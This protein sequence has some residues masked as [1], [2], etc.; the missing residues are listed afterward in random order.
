MSIKML[1]TLIA[2]AEHDTF[3]AAAAAVHVTHAAVSQ[4]MK[5]LEDEWQVALFDR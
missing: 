3:S 2:V 1:R 4:Q 5:H